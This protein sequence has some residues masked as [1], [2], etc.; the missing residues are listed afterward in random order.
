MN[1]RRQKLRIWWMDDEPDRLKRFPRQAIE[2]PEQL[3]DRSAELKVV[4]LDANTG[5]AE[6]LK[7]FER[8]KQKGRSPDLVVIDQM[9]QS[10][11][12]SMRRGSTLAV[13][14]RDEHPT[15]ALVGITGM[16]GSEMER[17]EELQKAQFIE[18]YARHQIVSG[19]H[20]PD[21]YAIAD[22]YRV[23]M[24]FSKTQ[25]S[26]SPKVADLCKLVKCPDD[27]VELFSSSVPGVFKKKWDTGTGHTFARWLW[28]ELQGRPG[29]LYDEL[30]TATLLGLKTEGLAFLKENLIDCQYNGVLASIVRPRWWGSR[31]R[32]QVRK[33][34]KANSSVPLWALGRDLIGEKNSS[35]FSKCHRRP[36]SN[37]VPTVVA[38]SDGTQRKRVQA[39]ISDTIPVET[40]SPPFGFEQRRV[41]RRDEA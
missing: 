1:A 14:I 28:H 16:T 38:F 24:A 36:M 31:V 40:D 19:N 2:H 30:E 22:G 41:I 5:V 29:F 32:Q 10:W 8:A 37:E 11:D 20:I 25:G 23:L 9:L 15:V 26:G 18:F 4:G 3:S 13:T 21:L 17:I 35:Y 33:L 39:L 6:V 27:D 12:D 34:K 7:E